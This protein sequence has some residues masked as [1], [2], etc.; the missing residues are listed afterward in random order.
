[1]VAE[2]ARGRSSVFKMQNKDCSNVSPNF[3][4]IIRCHISENNLLTQNLPIKQFSPVNYNLQT[5]R[6]VRYPQRSVLLASVGGVIK[7]CWRQFVCAVTIWTLGSESPGQCRHVPTAHA[8]R[9]RTYTNGSSHLQRILTNHVSWP[10]KGHLQ[11]ALKQY[12]LQRYHSGAYKY[13]I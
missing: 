9:I 5:C 11:F 7:F 6:A 4:Q 8:T 2:G 10:L 12:H 13:V 3:C 1:M